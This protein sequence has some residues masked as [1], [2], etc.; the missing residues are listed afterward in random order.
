MKTNSKQRYLLEN[1]PI[2]IYDGRRSYPHN[3]LD[4]EI[5][6]HIHQAK[7]DLNVCNWCNKL[8]KKGD[9]YVAKNGLIMIDLERVHLECDL[10]D[11]KEG[12]LYVIQTKKSIYGYNNYCKRINRDNLK[13]FITSRSTSKVIK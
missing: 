3:D 8:I 11:S 13:D 6:G 12:R 5:S 10:H 4:Y 7:K 9:L 2:A 1:R